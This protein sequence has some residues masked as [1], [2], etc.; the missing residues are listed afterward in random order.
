MAQVKAERGKKGGW[1]ETP[2]T[3][4]AKKIHW[5]CNKSSSRL[6]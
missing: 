2:R 5:V 4:Y 3:Q 1:R 6:A